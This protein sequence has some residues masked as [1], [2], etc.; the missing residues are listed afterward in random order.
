MRHPAL[1]YGIALIAVLIA[2][3]LRYALSPLI[4]PGHQYLTVFPAILIVAVI[5][6]RNPAIIT[7][8]LG[9]LTAAFLFE[10]IDPSTFIDISIVIATAALAG[11]LVQNLRNAII[12][13]EEKNRDLAESESFYRQTLESI[14][15]MVFTTRPDG[16]CDYRSRQW[17]EYTG[18]PLSEHMGDGWSKLLHPDD[19]ARACAAWRAAV[20]GRADYDVE[21]RVRRRDGK[22][23]WFKVRGRPIRDAAGRIVRWFGVAVNVDVFRR[24]QEEL[25]N[26]KNSL[27]EQKEELE[28]IISIVSHD[29]R[30]PLLN[31]RGFGDVLKADCK[32]VRRLLTSADVADDVR[33]K[34]DEIFDESAP[35]ALHF[36]DISARAMHDL[37]ESLVKVARAGLV[38]PRPQAIDMNQLVKE[39][40]ATIKIKFNHTGATI[41]VSDLPPCF[42]DRMHVTQA[43]TN[44]IDN[45]LKYLDPNR[46]GQICVEGM[47]EN[48]HALYWVSDNGIGIDPDHEQKVFDMFYRVDGKTGGGE[49]IG[50]SVVKRMIERNAGQIWLLS[51]KDK[52]SN[53]FIMLPLPPDYRNAAHANTEHAPATSH[54][55]TP[56]V[57]TFQPVPANTTKAAV[58][59]AIARRLN[60]PGP[61]HLPG[62]FSRVAIKHLLKSCGCSR[63]AGALPTL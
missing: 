53:F 30:A 19:R 50:L 16:Y 54:N 40:V 42:A 3:L 14:P 34:L 38:V 48:D 11:W 32:T 46:R 31:I 60:R 55:P 49:G 35:E 33:T 56:P 58:T 39:V 18:V 43:F 25:L 9:S 37:V 8:V 12:A 20:E 36:I 7:A 28:S 62:E 41:D 63:P 47:I 5:A 61:L 51:E 2:V 59:D 4:G 6:G 29:L 21:Y 24:A 15:G 45:A 26:L 52:G 22:Y 57:A 17:V 10:P 27:E 13:A 23:E 1:R 44:L